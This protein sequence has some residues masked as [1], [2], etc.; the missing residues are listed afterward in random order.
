MAGRP[1]LSRVQGQASLLISSGR[2]ERERERDLLNPI[3]GK[4]PL[5]QWINKD[6]KLHHDKFT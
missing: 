4:F 6:K 3:F 5:L 2:S 1:L